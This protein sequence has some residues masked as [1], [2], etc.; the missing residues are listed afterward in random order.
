MADLL[1]PVASYSGLSSWAAHQR[2]NPKSSEPG[3]DLYVP[4]GTPVVS[5]ADGFVY[6]YGESI[7]PAT[8]RWVGVNFDN[9]M[10]FRAMHFSRVERRSGRVRRG[11]VI[12]YS[13]ASGY[14]EEDWSWNVAETGGAHVHVTLWPNQ[15][16]GFG[17]DRNGR[18]F[19]VDFM[20][21]VGGSPAAVDAT[22][23]QEDDMYDDAAEKRLMAANAKLMEKLEDLVAAAAGEVIPGTTDM[24]PLA[25]LVAKAD[26]G[27]LLED[28]KRSLDI[29]TA[30]NGQPIPGTNEKRAIAKFLSG[31]G[32]APADVDEEAIVRGVLAGLAQNQSVLIDAI[33]ALPQETIAALKSAL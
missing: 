7:I 28:D 19:T 9:G 32:I 27:R 3:T 31:Q 30:L 25:R 11:E 18:P 21:Y 2:R 6:G 10:S 23:F 8:G 12:G 17:Y 5:P 16:R 14:G 15:S 22:P 33:R 4:I 20:N 13:G 26:Q 1:L 29:I 24:R